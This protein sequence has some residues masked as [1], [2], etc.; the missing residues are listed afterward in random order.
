VV[1]IGVDGVTLDDILVHDEKNLVMAQML[2]GLE[3]PEFPV[4]LGVLYANPTSSY[5]DDM[6]AQ[7]AAA[8]AAKSD[9]NALLRQ[10][11]TWQVEG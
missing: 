7:I 6:Y 5:N 3:P 1:T 8:G 2:A 9:L 11:R 10:G 4:A